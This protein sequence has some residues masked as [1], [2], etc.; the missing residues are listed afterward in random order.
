[1]E[2]FCENHQTP[3]CILCLSLQHRLCKT[4]SLIEKISK[5]CNREKSYPLEDEISKL[6]KKIDENIMAEKSNIANIDELTERYE[7]DIINVK[8]DV[9]ALLD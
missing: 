8:T 5:E 6:C 1:M 4:V 7:R 2:V 3:C 9:V